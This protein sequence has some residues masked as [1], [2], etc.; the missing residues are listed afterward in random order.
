MKKLIIEIIRAL[1][2]VLILICFIPRHNEK[3]MQEL[4]DQVIF[5]WER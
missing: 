1:V 2:I 3:E 5:P 4:D